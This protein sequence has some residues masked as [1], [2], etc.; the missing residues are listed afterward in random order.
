MH[1][2]T[3]DLIKWA[4]SLSAGDKVIFQR[5]DEKGIAIVTETPT[6]P[7]YNIKT[8]KGEF[9]IEF[10]IEKNY[11]CYYSGLVNCIYPITSEEEKKDAEEHD[12]LLEK[13]NQEWERKQEKLSNA[14]KGD[15]FYFSEIGS[16]GEKQPIPKVIAVAKNSMEI[17][18]GFL[19]Q[20]DVEKSKDDMYIRNFVVTAKE[21]ENRKVEFY[22][23]EVYANTIM[24][25][26]SFDF[27]DGDIVRFV[28]T[29]KFGIIKKKTEWSDSRILLLSETG[30]IISEITGNEKNI[31]NTGANAFLFNRKYCLKGECVACKNNDKNRDE[32]PCASCGYWL[33]LYTGDNWKWKNEP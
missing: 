29:D 12:A 2:K 20:A 22:M 23:V 6:P 18:K 11:G 19:V 28:G 16:Y 27:Y 26:I 10:Q 32:E 8:N 17:V 33:H 14:W 5:Y 15:N 4:K 9:S 1:M 31:V 7:N 30:E 24:P 21:V 25:R 13:V 3:D